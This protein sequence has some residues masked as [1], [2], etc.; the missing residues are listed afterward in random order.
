M[1]MVYG[2]IPPQAKDLEEV[3]LGAIMVDK[4]GYDAAM[5]ILKPE[6]FY[7]EANNRIFSAMIRLAVK[8]QPID[9]L[10]VSEELRKTEELEAVGGSYHISTLTNAVVSGANIRAHAHII[11]EKYLAREM[12][13]IGGEMVMNAYEDSTDV[14]ELIEQAEINITGI[15]QNNI[16]KPFKNL[17]YLMLEN[18]KEIEAMRHRD[19]HLTGISSGY[20]DLDMVTCGWQKTDLI[21][22]AARPSVGKTAL[23]LNLARNAAMHPTHPVP[24]A[25]FSLEMKDSQLVNRI[26]SSES[27]IWL[28]KLRNARIEEEGMKQLFKKG[29]VPLG[30]ADIW[31]DDTQS[32]NI[33]EFRSKARQLV[34]KHKVKIIFIDYMQLMSVTGIN[35]REQQIAHISRELKSAAKELNIPIIALAQLSRAVEQRG[36]E[37]EPKLSDLRESG[38]IEQDA[39]VVT[40]LWRPTDEEIVQDMSLAGVCHVKIEKHRNGDLAKFIGDFQKEIQKWNYL[41]VVDKTTLKPIGS[42]WKPVSNLIDYTSPKETNDPDEKM[43]F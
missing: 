10:T 35:N 11:M 42:N 20:I 29:L 43:P 36:G 23:A 4:S 2:K 38:S 13:R 25:I 16:R 31:I 24:V 5:E 19:E 34:N 32:L 37:K 7:V 28:W 18:F 15:L 9:I 3:V 41:K 21:I 26:L 14:F 27:G 22:L 40:F 8:S 30:A 6:C 17:S 1:T 33:S 39:D 12:I